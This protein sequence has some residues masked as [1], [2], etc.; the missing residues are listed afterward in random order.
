E[1]GGSSNGDNQ[2]SVRR[3]IGRVSWQISYA[4]S[5]RGH[6]YS[7]RQCVISFKREILFQESINVFE[8]EFDWKY[9]VCNF[10]ILPYICKFLLKFRGDEK[11]RREFAWGSGRK[12]LVYPTK[13]L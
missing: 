10:C 7:P 13:V 3:T 11:G 8:D 5:E 6:R 2:C 9:A 1:G 4:P 12:K